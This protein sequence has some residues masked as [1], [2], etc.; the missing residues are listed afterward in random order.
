MRLLSWLTKGRDIAEAPEQQAAEGSLFDHFLQLPS[1]NF[2]GQRSL[3]PNKRFTL[4]WSDADESGLRGGAR[5][6]GMGRYL[7][8]DGQ[9]VILQGR[10]ER[11]ND[12]KVANNGI[13]ILNDWEFTSELSGVF[14]AFR[15][16]GTRILSRRFK[17]NLYNNGLS[18]NGRL[19]VCQTC[20][21]PSSDDSSVLAVFDL[22]TGKEIAAWVP[23]S[24]WATV[25]NFP[26]D[27]ETIRLG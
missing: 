6:S 15:A 23:E 13:F 26:S 7:L 24:G 9:E 3:S 11:P 18:A 25:Y 8:L 20:N 1:Y 21:S 2:F 14:F 17:A 4:A 10:M 16:D 27:H 22:S 12:G 5:S 19:A